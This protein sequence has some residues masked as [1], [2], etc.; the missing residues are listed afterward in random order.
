MLRYCISTVVRAAG[1]DMKDGG[2]LLDNLEIDEDMI[3]TEFEDLAKL[4]S[5]QI[6]N[7][8]D[9]SQFVLACGEHLHPCYRDNVIEVKIS[10][11]ILDTLHFNFL[12]LIV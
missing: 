4:Y 11:F 6:I 8:C 12:I 9:F 5:D 7:F 3:D 2:V 10:L 1:D